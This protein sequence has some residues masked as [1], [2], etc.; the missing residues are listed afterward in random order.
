MTKVANT[1][2]VRAWSDCDESICILAKSQRSS[3]GL[4]R[5]V[6]REHSGQLWKNNLEKAGAR[7]VDP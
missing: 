6:H 5:L 3:P 4:G 1:G 2:V 7:L